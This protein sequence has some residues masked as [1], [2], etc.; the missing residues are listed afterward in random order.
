MCAS[1]WCAGDSGFGDANVQDTCQGLGLKFIFVAKL[2]QKVQSLCHHDEAAWQATEVP[3]LAVQEVELARPGAPVDRDPPARADRPQ[4]G[5]KTLLELAGYRFQALVTNLPPSLDALA[6]WRRY[7][8]RADLENRIKELG[9]QFGIKRLCVDSFWGTEACIIWPS[10][11]TT[12]VCSC[13]GASDSWKN[14]S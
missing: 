10:P 12:S 3:G 1:A 7:N 8:G 4:A 6:V 9:G 2:T 5:G 13:N 11:L 14:A